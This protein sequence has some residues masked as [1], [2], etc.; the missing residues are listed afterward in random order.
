MQVRPLPVDDPLQRRP[1]ITLARE[2]LKWEPKV[3]LEEG[4]RKTIEYFD[5]L[6]RENR[7][8]RSI[9]GSMLA[10]AAGSD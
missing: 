5:S 3:S 4:L 6:L 2:K 1:D 10:A 7:G 9:G 8:H